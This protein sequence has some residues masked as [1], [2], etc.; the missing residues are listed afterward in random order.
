M[1]TKLY[2]H[3]ELADLPGTLPSTEQS[4]LTA[5][6]NGDA[7]T[8]NRTMDTTIGTAQASITNTTTASASALSSYFTKFV[9]PPINQSGIAANTW[10]YAYAVKEAN[11]NANFPCTGANQVVRINVYV[12]RPST[13][14]IVGTILDGNTAATNS[15]GAANTEVSQYATFSGS[16]VA[17]AQAG[18]VIICEVWFTTTQGNAIARANIFYFDGTTETL[19]TGTT[20]SN[21]ASFINTPE[22]I[23]FQTLTTN[24]LYFHAASN[25]IANLPTAEQS[26]LTSAKNVDAQTVNRLMDNTI[27]ASEASITLSSINNTSANDYYFTKFVSW[28]L[29]GIS[30]INA[31][32][33]RYGFAASESNANA[34]FPV[35]A[36]NSP[37]YLNVYVWRPSSQTVVGT[38]IDGNTFSQ[39]AEPAST[40]SERSMY[41]LF[42]GA[43]VA[44]VSDDDVIICEVWFRVTQGASTAYNDIFYFDGTTETNT[45]NTVVTTHASYISTWQTLTFLKKAVAALPT[46]TVT[47]SESPAVARLKNSMRALPTETVSSSESVSRISAKWRRVGVTD[48]W[49]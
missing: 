41:C 46:E 1:A 20:V 21:H 27:G 42:Q 8:V 30:A 6:T 3:T 12:W 28:G 43:D 25:L 11:I 23:T 13:N 33:W 29:T 48:R 15:E 36:A 10:N 16:A 22:T 19:A 47:I 38:I 32:I 24:K 4:S 7:Q 17:G 35:G 5:T 14:T 39:L 31:G 40:N 44:S 18:D 9:S 37:V 2:F 26:A 45:V 34:N 49:F